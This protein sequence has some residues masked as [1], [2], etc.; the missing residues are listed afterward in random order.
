MLFINFF[1]PFD[2]IKTKMQAQVGYENSS[3]IG[4]MMKTV[5]KDGLKGLYR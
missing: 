5:K 1:K 2:T 4:T 3:M